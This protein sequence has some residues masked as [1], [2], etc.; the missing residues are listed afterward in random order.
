MWS[1]IRIFK[2]EQYFEQ[3]LPVMEIKVDKLL[4]RDI[5]QIES[6]QFSLF[7]LLVKC[8]FLIDFLKAIPKALLGRI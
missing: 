6:F 2:K 3:C 4:C 1:N 5:A 8:S 7:V